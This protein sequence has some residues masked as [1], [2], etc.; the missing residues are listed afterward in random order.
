MDPSIQQLRAFRVLAHELNFSRA[1]E[2]LH[3]SEP[4]LSRQIRVLETRVGTSLLERNSRVVT[5]TS[6]GRSFLNTVN[7][8]LVEFD[9]GVER[10]QRPESS[11]RFA[12]GYVEPLR[13]GLLAKVLSRFLILHPEVH[14]STYDLPSTDQLRRL[15]NRS[16]DC[17][18]L[19]SPATTDPAFEFTDAY[20]DNFVAAVP[21]QHPLVQRGPDPIPLGL[22]ADERFISYEGNIGQG[23]ISAM[24]SG[25]AASGFV[26]NVVRQVQNTVV[27]LALV[28]NCSG[29]ALVSRQLA[30]FPHANIAFLPLVGNPARSAIAFAVR[31]GEWSAEY[32]DLLHLVRSER[33]GE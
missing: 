18:L 2:V 4:S 16:L 13:Y 25:C 33:S 29:V 24:L 12:L 19:R 6:A 32:R 14:I 23:M 11:Y 27:L 30:N 5:L 22:L 8:M 26:P 21:A 28:A 31:K 15:A 20:V 7:L 17:A 9:Q 3:T 10:A 1:A